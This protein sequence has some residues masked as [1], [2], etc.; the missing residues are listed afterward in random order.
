MALS[1]RFRIDELVKKGSKAIDRDGS[2]NITVRKRNGKERKRELKKEVKPYGSEP[3][4]GK[5]VKD[6]FKSDLNEVD[7]TPN[8]D[9]TSFGGETSGYIER[10]KYNEEELKKAVDVKVDELIKPP[11]KQRGEY[12]KKLIYEE[13]QERFAEAN[14]DITGLKQDVATLEGVV[15]SLESEVVSLESEVESINTQLVAKQQELDGLLERYNK[16]LEDFQNAVI[17]GTKEGIERVSLTAQVQGLQAQKETL[18]TQLEAQQAI[19]KTL[20]QQ[21]ETQRQVAEQQVQAAQAATAQDTVNQRGAGQASGELAWTYPTSEPTRQQGSEA[22][23]FVDKK[24]QTKGWLRGRKIEILNS[25]TEAVTL[26]V[27]QQVNEKGI[28]LNGVPSTL[29]IPA[30]NDGGATP[31]K[32][33]FTVSR[34]RGLKKGTYKTT[35]TLKSSDGRS[36]TLKT[37]YRQRYKKYK[38]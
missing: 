32:K 18:Q 36:L 3:I 21:A 19:V 17:K 6:K 23:A 12:V 13:L 22:I 20:E 33:I 35:I 31:G 34:K 14:E 24:K 9:Q 10:P 8:V 1:D 7:N 15:A 11:K 2:G 4:R 5:K 29:R 25:G 30:S 26:N 27:T 38:A 37:Y 16:L 28:W